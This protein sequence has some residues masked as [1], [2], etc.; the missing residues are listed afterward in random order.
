MRMHRFLFVLG[1]K[2][3]IS[4]Y[5]ML[6]RNRRAEMRQLWCRDGSSANAVG[7]NGNIIYSMKWRSFAIYFLLLTK[8]L[9]NRKQILLL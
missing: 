8:F 3:R 1:K 4:E 2:M 5:K 9:F 6:M 7:A